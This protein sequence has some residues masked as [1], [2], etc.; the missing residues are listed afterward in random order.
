[1]IEITQA[2]HL[3]IAADAESQAAVLQSELEKLRAVAEYHR[4]I[5]GPAIPSRPKSVVAS[6]GSRTTASRY[7]AMTKHDLAKVVLEEH[8]PRMK[9]GDM[10]TK[11]NDAGFTDGKNRRALFN[12]LFTALNRRKDMFKKIGEQYELASHKDNGEK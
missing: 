5:G 4:R 2:M 8:G 3:K 6:V 9:I 7:S 12:A 10:V 11:L 1:M